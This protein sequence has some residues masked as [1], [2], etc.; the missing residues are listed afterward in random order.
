MD[1]PVTHLDEILDQKTRLG[2]LAILNESDFPSFG[3]RYAALQEMSRHLSTLEEAG[4]VELTK[5]TQGDVYGH[6]VAYSQGKSRLRKRN[7]GASRH[8]PGASGT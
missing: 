8:C 5:A 6:G 1:H 7:Q 2:M 3:R 4:L